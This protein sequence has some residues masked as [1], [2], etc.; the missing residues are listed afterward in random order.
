MQVQ[1]TV[2]RSQR[3]FSHARLLFISHTHTYLK[4]Y[5]MS[6]RSFVYAAY[7]CTFWISTM[8]LVKFILKLESVLYVLY[9][10][11]IFG[12]HAT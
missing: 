11:I 5:L 7:Y 3:E 8:Y 6:I 4:L 9:S 1:V 2:E 12:E 10:A